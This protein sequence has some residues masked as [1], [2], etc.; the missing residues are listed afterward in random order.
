MKCPYCDPRNNI[1]EKWCTYYGENKQMTRAEAVEKIKDHKYNP[2]FLDMLEALGLIKFEEEKTVDDL[3]TVLR[4]CRGTYHKN[5]EF[6][7]ALEKRGYEIVKREKDH[8]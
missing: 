1:H 8:G 5:D 4:E 6:I 3:E 7:K 2:Q